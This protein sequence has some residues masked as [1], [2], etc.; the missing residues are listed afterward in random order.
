LRRSRR[1]GQ[2]PRQPHRLPNSPAGAPNCPSAR[3]LLLRSIRPLERAPRSVRGLGVL[4][5]AREKAH[6]AAVELVCLK[7]FRKKP[8]FR[9]RLPFV[10]PRGIV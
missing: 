2:R 1:S 8:F 3:L 5:E 10:R 4:R 7:V 6:N 9:F